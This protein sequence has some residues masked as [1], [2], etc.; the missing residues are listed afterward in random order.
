MLGQSAHTEY[1]FKK[2]LVVGYR[3]PKNLRD[4]LVHAGIS[5]LVGDEEWDSHY[6]I[7][8]IPSEISKPLTNLTAPPAPIILRQSSITILLRSAD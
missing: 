8:V 3:Q 7:P 6:T 1:L 4:N 2:K 5:R